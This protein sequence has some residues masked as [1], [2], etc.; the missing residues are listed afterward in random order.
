VLVSLAATLAA[1]FVACSGG[2]SSSSPPTDVDGG[3][4]D[5]AADATFGD[6]AEAALPEVIGCDAGATASGCGYLTVTLQGGVTA[7]QCC[8][9]CASGTDGFAWELENAVSFDL[10]FQNGQPP[11]DQTGTFTLGSVSIEQGT[12]FPLTQWRTPPGACTITITRSVCV[13]RTDKEDWLEGTGTCTQPAAPVAPNTAAPVTIGDF[14]FKNFVLYPTAPATGSATLTGSLAEGPFTPVD[15][16][17]YDVR[18]QGPD[19]GM[20][21]GASLFVTQFSPACGGS[22]T[23]NRFFLYINLYT[24]APAIAPGTYPVVYSANLASGGPAADFTVARFQ[25]PASQC[26]ID[27]PDQ[28]LNGGTVTVSSV[29]SAAI[30]GTFSIPLE[31]GVVSGSFHAPYC[32]AGG[33]LACLP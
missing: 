24:P 13:M 20:V 5:A 16:V 28:A 11:L 1:V 7:H 8:Y 2:S 12:A 19:G 3:S 15:A 14:A 22:D 6:A 23:S 26:G 27:A 29:S 4:S 32:T 33:E 21:G 10:N 31:A 25:S 30:D 17:A 18:W 9:G